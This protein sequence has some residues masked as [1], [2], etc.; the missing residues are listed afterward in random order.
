MSMS[1]PHGGDEGEGKCQPALDLVW[2]LRQ[3]YPKTFLQREIK[4][5]RL[6]ETG[7]R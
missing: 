2:G 6:E 1:P 3:S 5:C 4:K 7:E